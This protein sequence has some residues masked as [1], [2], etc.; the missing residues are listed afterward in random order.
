[1]LGNKNSSIIALKNT[2]MSNYEQLYTLIILIT[3]LYMK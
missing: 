1:M 3:Q 2:V